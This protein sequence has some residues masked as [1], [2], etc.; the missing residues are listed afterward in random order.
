M[1]TAA[2]NVRFRS[3]D[4]KTSALVEYFA[5]RPATEVEVW[6]MPIHNIM[7]GVI[8]LSL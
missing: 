5:F 7:A 2:I 8:R 3:E 6:P 4:R 1:P